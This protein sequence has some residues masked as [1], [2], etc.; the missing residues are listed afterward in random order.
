[1]V[2]PIDSRAILLT[3]SYGLEASKELRRLADL[4]IID[5]E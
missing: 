1:M 5:K 3:K 4:K 2:L